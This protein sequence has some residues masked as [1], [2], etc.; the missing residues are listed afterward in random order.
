MTN[1]CWI[2]IPVPP[3]KLFFYTFSSLTLY[4]LDLTHSITALTSSLLC[5]PPL[6]SPSIFSL[7]QRHYLISLRDSACLCCWGPGHVVYS[8]KKHS[9]KK[10]QC[11]GWK[12]Q[13]VY[14]FLF[15]L[16]NKSVWP[17]C[18]SGG[19]TW[20][21]ALGTLMQTQ[22]HKNMC[23]DRRKHIYCVNIRFWSDRFTRHN[24]MLHNA[25]FKKNTLTF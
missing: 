10:K 13:I 2:T 5:S 3:L 4:S 1:S 9:L 8:L 16:L 20:G 18:P 23:L 24:N 7:F 22:I 12:L 15:V 19:F 14:W 25:S 21:I 11:L 6:R 17:W